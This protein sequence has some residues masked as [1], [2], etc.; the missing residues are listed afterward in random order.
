M[1]IDFLVSLI[2]CVIVIGVERLFYIRFELALLLPP[3]AA[4][5]SSPSQPFEHHHVPPAVHVS[6]KAYSG[7]VDSKLETATVS[8]PSGPLN[9]SESNLPVGGQS[10]GHLDHPTASS[11]SRQLFCSHFNDSR[12]TYFDFFRQPSNY[13]T[14][15]Y[16]IKDISKPKTYLMS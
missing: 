1:R 3:P 12:L 14:K 4:D 11:A 7:D 15:F 5:P 10:S 13:H 16:H 6:D 8:E 9:R 2:M